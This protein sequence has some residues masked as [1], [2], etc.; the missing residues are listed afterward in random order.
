M[1]TE[2]MPFFV[3]VKAQSPEEV[4]DFCT[5]DQ[6]FLGGVLGRSGRDDVDSQSMGERFAAKVAEVI[7]HALRGRGLTVSVSISFVREFF[8]VLRVCVMTP[9]SAQTIKASRT[10]DP[11]SAIQCC[12]CEAEPVKPAVDSAEITCM[13]GMPALV[14]SKLREH[15]VVVTAECCPEAEELQFLQ[16]LGF[17]NVWL[18]G[19]DTTTVQF[20]S[21]TGRSRG[22]GLFDHS[23]VRP[24]HSSAATKAP[25][26]DTGGFDS[27][28]NPLVGGCA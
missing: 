25:R 26:A 1:A 5:A 20:Q 22:G 11:W 12:G 6:G 4:S 24:R 10:F 14:I 8:S 19:K 13:A 3:N 9:M 2:S 27:D 7:L 21:Q 16:H 15:K 28:V 18:P 23:T 17:H